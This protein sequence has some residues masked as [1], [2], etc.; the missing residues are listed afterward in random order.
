MKQKL[1]IGANNWTKLEPALYQSIIEKGIENG[2]TVFEAGQEGGDAALVE[3]Y[4]SA[5]SKL[6]SNSNKTTPITMTMRIGYRTVLPPDSTTQAQDVLDFFP[7][8]VAVEQHPFLGPNRTMTPMDDKD[9][10]LKPP[11]AKKT[12]G[13]TQ[14]IQILHNMK[15]VYIRHQLSTS[16]L[17]QEYQKEASSSD[18]NK[19]SNLRIVALVH[20]PEAQIMELANEKNIHQVSQEDR[21]AFL[22]EK[23]VEAF[24]ALETAVA[25]QQISSYGVASNGLGL[26]NEHP[27]FLHKDTVLEAAKLAMEKNGSDKCHMSCIQLPINLMERKGLYIA[28]ELHSK[29]HNKD[30]AADDEYQYLR[31]DP[32]LEIYAMRPLTCYPDRGTGTG[33]AFRL[34]DY[35]LPSGPKEHN[36]EE[37]VVEDGEAQEVDKDQISDEDMTSKE[38]SNRMQGPPLIYSIAL[39]KAMQHFDA[40]HLL[41]E[42]MQ[43][44]LTPEE[45][46][47][48]D[49]CKLLQSM[50]H[51]LDVTL[52]DVRSLGA[53]E[54]D[55]YQRIIP[56]IH[57]TFEGYD[58]E[59]ADVLQMFFKA[60]ALAVRYSIAR[61]TRSLLQ[62]GGD[63]G[64]SYKYEDIP[65]EEKLQN[66]ALMYL[67]KDEAISKVIVGATKVDH[68]EDL[69]R[70]C[71]RLDAAPANSDSSD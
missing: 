61:N 46:E 53:H 68:V 39:K 41:E 18:N 17:V 62:N 38:W 49:G 36:K 30:D 14:M 34:V 7:G 54:Q 48:L 9:V 16:P 15:S 6:P 33:H 58:E 65:D 50:L 29:I 56:L 52:A 20:N 21:Q 24:C 66:Y 35:L 13:E 57:D 23:L 47:T 37:P 71:D 55:L 26:P 31:D 3:A 2:L 51:D 32:P 11:A 70:L 10:N 60:Y 45:R 63:D 27:L 25:D 42:K 22:R 40:E 64:N 5:K 4:K 67:M 43:R 8:D 12:N 19:S 69:V 1:G 59:T 44:D 28:R